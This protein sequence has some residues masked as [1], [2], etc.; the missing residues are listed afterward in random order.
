MLGSHF[1]SVEGLDALPLW[2]RLVAGSVHV[3]TWWHVVRWLVCLMLGY[4]SEYKSRKFQIKANIVGSE[5]NILQLPVVK[6]T[7]TS[8]G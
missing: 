1:V 7:F 5:A 3:Q 4:T 6:L 2:K 8:L